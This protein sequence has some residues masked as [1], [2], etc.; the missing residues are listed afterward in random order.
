MGGPGDLPDVQTRDDA[1]ALSF[2]TDPLPEDLAVF[3]QAVVR[4]RLASDKPD[5]FVF[6]RL[7][8]VAEDGESYLVT[9][10]NL[11]LTH[12]LGHDEEVAAVPVGELLDYEIPLK[13][14]A[15]QV[16]AG[17]RLRV[18]LSTSYWPWIWPSP[19]RAT[20]T[21]DLDR[22]S[23]TVPLLDPTLAVPLD[24]AWEPPAIAQPAPV[25]SEGGQLA[26]GVAGG[27][28]ARPRSSETAAP[29]RPSTSRPASPPSTR[30]R[31]ATSSTPTTR[32]PPRWRPSAP[33]ASRARTGTSRRPSDLA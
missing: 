7:T 17:R 6:V 11:N 32:S 1:D 5:T 30:T 26:V 24:R 25:T 29:P 19:E 9:R 2:T 12:R 21:V 13:H 8:E 15:Q 27:R 31:P 28:R 3:G 33:R 10:G 20:I 22:T 16:P 18:S 23:L 14:I 4:I